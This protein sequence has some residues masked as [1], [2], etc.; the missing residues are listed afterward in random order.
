MPEPTP[1][2]ESLKTCAHECSLGVQLEEVEDMGD[3]DGSSN[4]ADS[5]FAF[6]GYISDNSKFKSDFDDD[7][8]WI[9]EVSTVE[10]LNDQFQAEAAA[11]AQIIS[12][13][14]MDDF[15]AFNYKVETHLGD[16]AYRKLSRGFRRL[17]GHIS[18]IDVLQRRISQLSGVRPRQYKCCINSCCCYTRGYAKLQHCPYCREPRYDR[19]GR[20]VKTFN[21]LPLIPRL[22]QWFRN[23]EMVTS[24]MYRSL[25]KSSP[26]D[27]ENPN[28]DWDDIVDVFN[29]EHYLSLLDERQ[30]CW[31][32]VIFNYNLPPEIRFHLDNILCLGVI[33]GLK[34]AKDSNSFLWPFVEEMLS[35]AKGVVAFDALAKESFVLHAYVILAFGDIPAVAKLMHMKGHNG[36]RP[37]RMCMISGIRIPPPT[38]VKTLYT[39]L[40]RPNGQHYDPLNLPLR[41]H[42]LFINQAQF[43]AAAST[44]AEEKLRATATGVKGMPVLAELSS[45][46]FPQ[47]F[48]Y[49]FMHAVWENIIKTLANLWC[50]DYKKLD[51]GKE[52]YS[53]SKSVWSAI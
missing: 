46:R 22:K 21:Y 49:D 34:Q 14:D 51:D 40:W 13:E 20:P 28:V 23:P 39:P 53:F 24:L 48:P 19:Q 31:P 12:E 38:K 36:H 37:C 6:D 7:E 8:L 17:A 44:D 27:P 1:T 16:N 45:L 3:M 25:F 15:E 42:S 10:R 33:P 32:I 5:E 18:S 9:R 30:T 50:G 4:S 26:P 2:L 52:E 29:G 47:S 35:L 43:V 41:N 11:R